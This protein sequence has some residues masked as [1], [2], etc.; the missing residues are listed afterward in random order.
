MDLAAE[1]II[2]TPIRINTPTLHT[3]LQ[4]QT[5][6]S[7]NHKQTWTEMGTRGLGEVVAMQKGVP[8]AVSACKKKSSGV[9]S[10]D[11]WMVLGQRGQVLLGKGWARTT[12]RYPIQSPINPRWLLSSVSSAS[13][14]K[15]KT[16][17]N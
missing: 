11:G 15:N 12:V 5:L 17:Q 1:M 7:I 4:P 3:S 13:D 10:M 2:T 9:G 14:K 16:T 6:P 8:A